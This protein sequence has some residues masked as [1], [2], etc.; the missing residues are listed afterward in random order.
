M[1]DRAGR[2]RDAGAVIQSICA[3]PP[4][5]GMICLFP[6]AGAVESSTAIPRSNDTKEGQIQMEISPLSEQTSPS[7]SFLRRRRCTAEAWQT[8]GRYFPIVRELPWNLTKHLNNLSERQ[9]TNGCKSGNNNCRE[10][11]SSGFS[12]LNPDNGE[13]SL[14]HRNLARMILPVSLQ[15]YLANCASLTS[16]SREGRELVRG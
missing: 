2:I 14:S 11:C 15:I 10:Y 8:N 5:R 4:H 16:H 1:G 6:Q 3:C 7:A 9:N 12:A 13:S